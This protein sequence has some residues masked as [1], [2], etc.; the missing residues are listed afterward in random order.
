LVILGGV[1]GVRTFHSLVDNVSST[2]ILCDECGKLLSTD[3]CWV[4]NG[5][6]IC[7]TEFQIISGISSEKLEQSDE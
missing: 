6:N 3:D 5:R 1:D 4:F 2:R 7:K